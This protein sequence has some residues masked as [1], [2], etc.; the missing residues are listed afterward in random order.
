VLVA[1][2]LHIVGIRFFTVVAGARPPANL[3]VVRLSFAR[4]G[5]RVCF[6][7][8]I[9]AIISLDFVALTTLAWVADFVHAVRLRITPSWIVVVHFAFVK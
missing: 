1:N 9:R 3:T 5:R 7:I 8:K 6:T 2:V 4:L